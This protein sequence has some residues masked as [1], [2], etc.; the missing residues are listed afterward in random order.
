[1]LKGGKGAIVN[2]ASILGKVAFAGAPAYTAAK[3][4][5]VGLTE[6][7][8][9]DYAT[10]GIRINAVCPGFINTPMVSGAG[11][12]PG[13]DAYNAIAG[14]HAMKRFGNPQE[15]AEAVVWLCSD[16][17]SFVTGTSLVVDGGYTAM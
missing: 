17:A 13:T 3:H 10:Q 8:A 16:T 1:M 6:T 14:L 4:G 7:A 2:I 15:I 9:L 12:G 5:V 11:M